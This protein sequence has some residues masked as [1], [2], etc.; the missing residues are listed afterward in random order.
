MKFP[1]ASGGRIRNW[2]WEAGLLLVLPLAFYRGFAEQFSTPKFFL[3]KCL[4][5]TG[6][7]VWALGGVWTPALRRVRFPLG[8][9]VARVQ[10]GG[11]DFLSGEP[12]SSFQPDGS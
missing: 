5:I 1:Q 12:G 11:A 7:A 8:L 10:Y 6:L 2:I 3:T 9:A 4:I